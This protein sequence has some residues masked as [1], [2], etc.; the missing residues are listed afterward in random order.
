[1]GREEGF[2]L[3]FEIGW[4]IH[5]DERKD[6]GG[7]WEIKMHFMAL[8]VLKRKEWASMLNVTKR[9]SKLKSEKCP[10]DLDK[11]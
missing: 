10:F 7:Q 6:S 8:G 2:K 9:S 4:Q 1:M 3:G 5:K 11:N